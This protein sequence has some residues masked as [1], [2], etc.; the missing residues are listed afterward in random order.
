MDSNEMWEQCKADQQIINGEVS[1][2]VFSE[3]DDKL[4]ELIKAG[5]KRAVSY[6]LDVYKAENN[7]IPKE[8]S[9]RV[10]MNSKKEPICVVIITKAY[11]IPFSA[12]RLSHAYLEGENDRMLTTWRKTHEEVFSR[13]LEKTGKSFNNDI[14]VLCVEFRVVYR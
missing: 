10:I 13:Q 4:T 8:D 7:E 2:W 5:T 12:V 3:A 11:E 6:A 14:P 9:Y 1:E